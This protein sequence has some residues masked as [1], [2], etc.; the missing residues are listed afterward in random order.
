MRRRNRRYD[1]QEATLEQPQSLVDKFRTGTFLVIEDN[2][3]SELQKRLDAYSE[4][5][6]RFGFLR[7]LE[8]LRNEKVKSDRM[9]NQP[10]RRLPRRSGKQPV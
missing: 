6:A 3:A 4:I 1:D 10:A 7:T 5:A 8:E 9:R 2:I